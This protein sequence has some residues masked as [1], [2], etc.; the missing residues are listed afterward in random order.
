[1]NVWII[2]SRT[3]R[4]QELVCELITVCSTEHKAVDWIIEAHEK[5]IKVADCERYWFGVY[6]EEVDIGPNKVG[7]S[8]FSPYTRNGTKMIG[9]CTLEDFE[10][11]NVLGYN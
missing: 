3:W 7:T 6:S 2:E 10:D 9:Q 5:G 11:W 4:N 8:F 1:M